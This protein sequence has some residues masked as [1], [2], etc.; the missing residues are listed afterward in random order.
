MGWRRMG[1][2]RSAARLAWFMAGQ[3]RRR[4]DLLRFAEHPR[5]AGRSAEHEHVRVLGDRTPTFGISHWPRL[6]IPRH[7]P[8][9][10]LIPRADDE[11]LLQ[12]H[13]LA[14]ARLLRP[15]IHLLPHPLTHLRK[16]WRGVEQQPITVRVRLLRLALAQEMLAYHTV[17]PGAGKS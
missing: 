4:C 17:D 5:C 9:H 7:L 10:P 8:E 16:L 13:L 15:H 6:F 12:T 2:G 11:R 3:P 14:L 1:P